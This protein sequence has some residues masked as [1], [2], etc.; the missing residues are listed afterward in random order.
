MDNT[1]VERKNAVIAR[2]GPWTAHNIYLGDGVYTIKNQIVGDEIKLQGIVQMVSDLYGES[3]NQLR[4]L[5]LGCLEGL[6]SLEL[7]RRG[8]SVVAIDGREANIEKTRFAKEALSLDNVEIVQDDVRNLCVANY[9]QFDIVLCL[10]LLYHLDAPDVFSFIE[11]IA[12][13]CKRYAIIDT[14]VSLAAKQFRSFNGMKYWGRTF[15]EH[16]SDSTTEDRLKSPWASLDNPRSFWLTRPSL[17]TIL[18]HAQFTSVY[19]CHI[20]FEKEKPF[21]RVTLLAIKGQRA[22][23]SSPLA[24][25][26]PREDWPERRKLD[27]HASQRWYSDF[28]SRRTLIGLLPRRVRVLLKRVLSRSKL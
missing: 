8:A 14:R 4:I 16:Y 20:P 2:F 9:G 22:V 5:D 26:I 1:I 13:V 3:L 19:E 25:S 6:Y 28:A 27:V 18:S 17:Y 21:D 15:V 11:G 10:G 7:A 12:Q 23:L 24:N